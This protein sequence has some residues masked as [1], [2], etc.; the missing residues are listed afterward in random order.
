MSYP[1]QDKAKANKIKDDFEKDLE[2]LEKKQETYEKMI[3]RLR[4]KPIPPS[5]S[6]KLK[7]DRFGKE[8][9]FEEIKHNH[10]KNT[11]LLMKRCERCQYNKRE[12]ECETIIDT[13]NGNEKTSTLDI[14]NSPITPTLFRLR[15]DRGRYDDVRGYIWEWK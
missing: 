15:I 6:N 4:K 3:T 11:R 2:K 10:T 1:L 9:M 13:L 5:L 8:H 12:I 14:N 7:D